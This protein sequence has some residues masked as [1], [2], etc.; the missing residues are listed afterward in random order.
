MPFDDWSLVGYLWLAICVFPC[1]VGVCLVVYGLHCYDFEQSMV[2][3]KTSKV[4]DVFLECFFIPMS[5]NLERLIQAMEHIWKKIGSNT[6][7]IQKQKQPIN[8]NLGVLFSDDDIGAT[9]KMILG[10]YLDVTRNVAGCQAIRK[11]IG[12]IL[13]GFRCVLA[14]CYSSQY[15]QT[16]DTQHCY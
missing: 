16:D 1:M 3:M 8:G 11:K 10:S 12:H 4:L 13:F 5:E 14:K 7:V 9:E 6:A 15:H 2:Q